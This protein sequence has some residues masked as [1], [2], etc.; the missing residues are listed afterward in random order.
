M[1]YKK[2]KIV[3]IGKSIHIPTHQ[4]ANTKENLWLIAEN[5]RLMGTIFGL[6]RKCKKL[7]GL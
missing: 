5:K 4:Y 6:S 3:E 2:S 7:Q 1:L